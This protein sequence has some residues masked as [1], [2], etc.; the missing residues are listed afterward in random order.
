MA[1]QQNLVLSP[2]G[3]A[4]ALGMTLPGARGTTAREIS[5]VLHTELP[6]DRYA[7]ALG[8]LARS[9]RSGGGGLVLNQSDSAWT[10]RG[11]PVDQSYLALLAAAF[12]TGLY[13]ADFAK[14]PVAATN[15]VNALVSQQTG[16]RITDL[17]AP[18]SLDAHTVLTLT[19]ALYFTAVWQS[20]F[21][22][23][24]TAGRTFHRLDGSTESVP[25]M[26]QLS[27]LRY[28]KGGGT[29]AQPA[30]QAVELPYKGVDLAMDLVLP[31]AGGLDAFRNSLTGAGLDAML[32]GLKDAEV[33]L[34]MPKFGFNSGET[35]NRTLTA[36]GMPSAFGTSAD[37]SGIA[38]SGAQDRLLLSQVVQ[39][40]MVLVDEKGTTA[41][42]GSGG[43]G[44][45]GAPAPPT[46]SVT[47]VIDHP[48]LF[49]IRNVRTGQPLFLGQVT[50]PGLALSGGGPAGG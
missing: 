41:A 2:A 12:H 14:D 29:A 50:D 28:A 27:Q 5:T 3:L 34:A 16:G 6:A 45:A 4:T 32:G 15:A 30:W 22:P 47:L 44:E 36:L 39:K 26:N 9:G 33:R 38:G 10:Q 49:L 23:D 43:G 20:P 37:F 31:G 19:D 1:G 11:Y 17:F 8:A 24:A 35:L 40:A 18:G 48:F 42:A 46:P 7:M 25:M 21:Q 13:T